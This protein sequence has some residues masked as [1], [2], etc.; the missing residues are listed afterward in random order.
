MQNQEANAVAEDEEE[1]DAVE[2]EDNTPLSA[3]R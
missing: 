2:E 3:Y 1:E